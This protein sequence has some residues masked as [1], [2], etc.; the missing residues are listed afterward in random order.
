MQDIGKKIQAEREKKSLSLEE[1]ANFLNINKKYI[2]ALE[3]GRIEDFSSPAYYY[4]YLHQYLKLLNIQNLP[5]NKTCTPIAAVSS[6][7]LVKNIVPSLSYNIAVIL[8]CFAIY[9]IFSAFIT[10]TSVDVIALEQQQ[11]IVKLAEQKADQ[12]ISFEIKD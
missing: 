11:R 1:I 10:S 7:P 6:L 2:M 12:T 9:Y 8:L 3:E 4:G 5:Q